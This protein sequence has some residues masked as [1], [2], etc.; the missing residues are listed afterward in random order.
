MWGQVAKVGLDLYA[1]GLQAKAQYEADV[2][3][4]KIQQLQRRISANREMESYLQNTDYLKQQATEQDVN[5]TRLAME[6]EDAAEM[7]MAGS[8]FSGA[9]VTELK[10]DITRNVAEDRLALERGR[11]NQQD[12]LK[13]QL[14]QAGENRVIETSMAT[15]PNYNQGITNALFQSVGSQLAVN[16]S[17]SNAMRDGLAGLFKAT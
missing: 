13:S 3:T 5:L 16:P 2:A 9:S 11:M 4:S 6:A 7:A 12:A 1:A 14:R 8:G 10:A 15:V 17:G